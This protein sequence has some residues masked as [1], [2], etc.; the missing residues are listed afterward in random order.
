MT[1]ERASA[2]DWASGKSRTAHEGDKAQTSKLATRRHCRRHMIMSAVS[3]ASLFVPNI[4][5]RWRED[6]GAMREEGW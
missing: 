2:T 5:W 6:S 1:A 4:T 3:L